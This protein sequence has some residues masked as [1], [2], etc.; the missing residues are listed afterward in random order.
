MAKKPVKKM[1]SGGSA[2]QRPYDAMRDESSRAITAMPYTETKPKPKPKPKAPPPKAK[3][4]PYDPVKDEPTSRPFKKGGKVMRKA[5]GG[6]TSSAGEIDMGQ[7]V[8]GLGKGLG[9]TPS[10]T[11]PSDA[12]SSS[13]TPSGAGNSAGSFSEAFRAARKNMLDNGGPKTFTWNG[14]S[15]STALA[16]DNRSAKKPATPTKSAAPARAPASA[17]TTP[18]KVSP[19]R[20]RPKQF[21]AES[22]PRRYDPNK[23]TTPRTQAVMAKNVAKADSLSAAAD[24]RREGARFDKKGREISFSNRNLFADEYDRYGKKA[25]RAAKG[26]RIK[27]RKFV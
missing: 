22:E 11:T 2:K 7:L 20:P 21:R 26:G 23:G 13:A 18:A 19:P 16:G 15:Y 4:R 9:P 12:S 1:A 3:G 25:T 8:R 10:F 27:K 6:V 24:K 14:K 5:E 17:P